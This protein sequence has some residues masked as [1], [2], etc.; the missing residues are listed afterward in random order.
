M[1]TNALLG[2][3]VTKELGAN[4][5]GRGEGKGE[6]S[7]YAPCHFPVTLKTGL[8]FGRQ[9]WATWLMTV[10]YFT[11]CLIALLASRKLFQN[12]DCVYLIYWKGCKLGLLAF[13]VVTWLQTETQTELYLK[14]F[15]M[16][17][18]VSVLLFRM[19]APSV[20]T[21]ATL[22]FTLQSCKYLLVKM[23][24]LTLVFPLF[25]LGCRM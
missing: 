9:V 13:S 24:H 6:G 19:A 7:S 15:V 16:K 20:W 18:L 5:G 11:V 17:G 14:K 21:I 25:S 23:L 12:S 2:K 22:L 3:P 1:L 10:T 4:P 8:S